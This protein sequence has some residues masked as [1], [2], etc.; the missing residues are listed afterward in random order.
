M[1]RVLSIQPARL[2]SGQT[3]LE[4]SVWFTACMI[5]PLDRGMYDSASP[6]LY[7]SIMSHLYWCDIYILQTSVYRCNSVIFL[8]KCGYKL[9]TNSRGFNKLVGKYEFVWSTSLIPPS[10][11]KAQIIDISLLDGWRLCGYKTV[12]RG[13]TSFPPSTR[14]NRRWAL[15]YIYCTDNCDVF[16]FPSIFL[17]L[18]S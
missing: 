18:I 10:L 11:L 17:E 12:D 8:L 4:P 16:M 3:L 7:F 2:M 1:S 9:H 5:G 13:F 14:H 15:Y 6:F